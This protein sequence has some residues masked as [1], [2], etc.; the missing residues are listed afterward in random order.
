M[1]LHCIVSLFHPNPNAKTEKTN[2]EFYETQFNLV[3][4]LCAPS[5]TLKNVRAL[6]ISKL[7]TYTPQARAR[8]RARTPLYLHQIRSFTVFRVRSVIVAV[9]FL[10]IFVYLWLSHLIRDFK[11]MDFLVLEQIR[12]EIQNN[13]FLFLW[14]CNTSNVQNK[15]KQTI[16][17]AKLNWQTVHAL[18]FTLIACLWLHCH[19][20]SD[21]FTNTSG[22][23]PPLHKYSFPFWFFFGHCALV[24]NFFP[25][26]I[27]RKVFV[28][29][30]L[31]S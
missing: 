7:S 26:P 21:G 3:K 17:L 15:T 24:N 18:G 27:H 22:L 5:T 14:L 31:V 8:A 16:G 10:R 9:R 19:S 25:L 28:W 13:S 2:S 11:M 6:K 30:K 12:R 4:R 29:F 1:C 23:F 20:K